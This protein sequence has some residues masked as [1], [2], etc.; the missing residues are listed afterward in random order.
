MENN[1][2]GKG[3]STKLTK[4]GKPK[5]AGNWSYYAIHH[6]S[7]QS[8]DYKVKLIDDALMVGEHTPLLCLLPS[9]AVELAMTDPHFGEYRQDG[10]RTVNGK[11]YECHIT[12]TKRKLHFS[13]DYLNYD[14]TYREIIFTDWDFDYQFPEY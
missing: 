1:Y 8:R 2:R 9:A 3:T 4:D 6:Q 11:K 5:H 7:M 13:V 12:L 14:F 10:V